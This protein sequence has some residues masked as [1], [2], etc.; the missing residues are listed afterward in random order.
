MKKTVPATVETTCDIC[1]KVC[2]Q[3]NFKYKAYAM[4]TC[5]ALNHLGDPCAKGDF[6]L[7]LCDRCFREIN[8]YLESLKS[9]YY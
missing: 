1:N 8:S 5:A 6:G 9:K 3:N 4:F 7:D 2:E